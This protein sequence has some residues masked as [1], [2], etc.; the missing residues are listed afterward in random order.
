MRNSRVLDQAEQYIHK[1]H[2][3]HGSTNLIHDGI[4][5]PADEVLDA[6]VHLDLLEEQFELQTISIELSNLR[7]SK[8]LG[9]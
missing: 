2:C 6:K 9:V 7:V 4:E 3:D 8:I 1:Q 5:T